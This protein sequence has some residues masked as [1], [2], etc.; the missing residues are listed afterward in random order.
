MKNFNDTTTITINY[1][2]S[3]TINC[4]HNNIVINCCCCYHSL[5]LLISNYSY[6]PISSLILIL[7]YVTIQHN[8]VYH[9]YSSFNIPTSLL[10]TTEPLH[11]HTPHTPPTPTTTTTDSIPS[12]TTLTPSSSSP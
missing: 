3:V 11:S 4:Y 10:P 9:Y 5:N 1:Y 2:Y 7:F 8:H 12:S 6:H